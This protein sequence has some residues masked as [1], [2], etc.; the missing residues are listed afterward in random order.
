MPNSLSANVEML[1][2]SIYLYVFVTVPR[3]GIP[4][5]KKKEWR[6]DIWKWAGLKYGGYLV[7]VTKTHAL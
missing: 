3:F 5:W 7:N 2:G 6:Y 4:P 1:S